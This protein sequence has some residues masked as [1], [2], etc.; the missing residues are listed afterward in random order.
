MDIIICDLD[1]K[2]PTAVP[3][4]CLGFL[5]QAACL[6]IFGNHRADYDKEE[7]LKK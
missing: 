4:Q 5:G 2:T 6:S 1:K 7:E 3:C